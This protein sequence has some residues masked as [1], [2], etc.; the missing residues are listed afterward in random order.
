MRR[1]RSQLRRSGAL[2][3]Q[4]P[5]ERGGRASDAA[6]ELALGDPRRGGGVG[7]VTQPYVGQVTRSVSCRRGWPRVGAI[8]NRRRD[9]RT[10]LPSPLSL[11]CRGA[12]PLVGGAHSTIPAGVSSVY[13]AGG[14]LPG[15]PALGQGAPRGPR[16]PPGGPPGR[17]GCTFLGVFN[18][19]P[20]RDKTFSLFFSEIWDKTSGTKFWDKIPGTDSHKKPGFRP[21]SGPF[22]DL[23]ETG[24]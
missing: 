1:S 2:D 14:A 10:E 22:C 16:G 3:P 4:R 11:G 23:G 17:P 9:S 21:N 13:P 6:R 7:R 19:S 5:Q 24:I 18:N 8:V 20:I 15:G 12:V